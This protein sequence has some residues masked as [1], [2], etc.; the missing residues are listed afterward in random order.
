ML[1]AREIMTTDVVTVT[2]D[3]SVEEAAAVMS[4]HKISGLPVVDEE[5]NLAGILSERDLIIKDKNLHF[6][7]YINVLGGIIYLDS[8]KKFKEEFR[9]YIA[10]NV[11]EMMTEDVITVGPE[12]TVEDIATIMVEE[13]INRVP[14]VDN[15]KLIGI[16][17]RGD[18]V[19]DIAREE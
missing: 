10:Q 7:D 3:T 18:L 19:K 11:G 14:V 8:Y 1:T 13:D 16:V 2:P 5:G 9:K 4:E 12:K 15:K 6:P 17:T